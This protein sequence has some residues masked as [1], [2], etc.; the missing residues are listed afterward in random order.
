[1]SE[2]KKDTTEVEPLPGALHSEV[3]GLLE[4]LEAHGGQE[5]VFHIA[6]D[7]H[8]PYSQVITVANAAELLDLVESPRRLIVLNSEG[9]RLI[10]A[11]P[12]ERRTLW[13]EKLLRLRLFREVQSLVEHA[14]H[15]G[16]PRDTLLE[17]FVLHLPDENCEQQLDTFV[18]WARYGEL[19]GYDERSQT[20]T[21]TS[22]T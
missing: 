16:V 17:T 10:R 5:D 21:L 19:F 2:S 14:G 18:R 7:T 22:G 6:A 9:R 1:M 13:R 8:R 11:G 12:I 20:L 15:N 4:Y 3:I